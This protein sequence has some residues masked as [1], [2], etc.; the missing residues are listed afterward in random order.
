MAFDR[1]LHPRHPAPAPSPPS[2]APKRGT[3]ATAAGRCGAAAALRGRQTVR[4]GPRGVKSTD[5]VRPWRFPPP[6]IARA[7]ICD[8]VEFAAEKLHAVLTREEACSSAVRRE[9]GP[10]RLFQGWGGV[11]ATAGYLKDRGASPPGES[12]A[13]VPPAAPPMTG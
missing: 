12:A 3:A 6:Q 8:E 13:P 4:A 11:W 5:P 9:R 1:P 7:E 2:H 10:A